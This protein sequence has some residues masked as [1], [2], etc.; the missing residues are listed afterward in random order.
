MN[1]CKD[2]EKDHKTMLEIMDKKTTFRLDSS[3]HLVSWFLNPLYY[4]AEDEDAM[5]SSAVK[6]V[7]FDCVYIVF[8]DDPN[9]LNAIH[10]RMLRY[11]E[12]NVH[13]KRH[14]KESSK[15]NLRD[16]IN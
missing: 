7:M 13:K 15:R 14:C 5:R 8:K 12:R 2:V 3:L 1:A 16:T 6:M 4:Y 11:E 9:I 10:S